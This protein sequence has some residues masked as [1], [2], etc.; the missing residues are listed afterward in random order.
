MYNSNAS[1]LQNMNARLIYPLSDEK[2]LMY[3]C[4]CWG[5]LVAASS[6]FCV[7]TRLLCQ[8]PEA[9]QHKQIT[10]QRRPHLPEAWGEV[11][12]K[13]RA[14]VNINETLNCYFNAHHQCLESRGLLRERSITSKSTI[15]RLEWGSILFNYSHR[16]LARTIVPFMFPL[17]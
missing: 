17:L 1:E 7:A 13:T 2:K 14:N 3:N 11:I 8:D 9:Q 5:I 4:C 10:R 6:F 15:R 12:I 16:I